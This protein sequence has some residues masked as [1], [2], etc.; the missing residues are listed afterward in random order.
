MGIDS[1]SQE[2]TRD[3]VSTCQPL[4]SM[5]VAICRN[6]VMSVLR[7]IVCTHPPFYVMSKNI[8]E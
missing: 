5:T 4:G 7:R 6:V 3:C 2:Y 8:I 1:F